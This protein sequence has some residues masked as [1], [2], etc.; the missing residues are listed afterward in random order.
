MKTRTIF[1]F[2]LASAVALV[3]LATPQAGTAQKAQVAA[4]LEPLPEAAWDYAKARHLL[5]RAGFGGSPAEVEKLHA[6]GLRKA[7][8]YLVDYHLIPDVH[9]PLASGLEGLDPPSLVK[10]SPQDKAKLLGDKK[11]KNDVQNMQELRRWWANKMVQ[12]PRPLEEKLVLF[13]H[14]IFATE[15]RTVRNAMSMSLQN[16]LF[17]EH[18]AGNY[19]KLLHAIIYDAA[20]LRYLDNNTNKKGKP[21]EN[22]AREIMEL[23]SMGESQGYTEKDVQQ[24]AR[25]LTG[26]TFD[27]KTLEPKFIAKEHDDGD[28]TIFGKTQ[29]FNGDQFVDLILEQ[30][31][32]S[33][34]IA[35]RLFNYFVYDEPSQELIG[36]LATVLKDGKYEIKPFLR[37]VFLSREFYSPKAMGTHHK[38]PAQLVVGTLRI[39]GIKEVN[40][41]SLVQAM[42][43]MNQDLFDPPNVKGWDGGEAWINSVTL[44]ARN[45]FT[46]NLVSRGLST[47]P[48]KSAEKGEKGDKKGKPV[49]PVL[50]LD[51]VGALKDQKIDT[52][53]AVVDFWVRALLAVPLNEQN[54]ARLVAALGELPPPDQWGQRKDEINRKI[55]NLLIII[56]SL[57]EYQLA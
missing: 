40:G 3:F 20:M 13:W 24:G 36:Q 53:A 5:F 43:N 16:Q 28:I 2:L 55:G 9:V 33:R 48:V 27:G 6:M 17:R 22:L 57:P 54:R 56:M 8:D 47:K 51:F 1:C 29:K 26:Y 35:Y 21:N 25:A 31:A 45:N 15:W 41:E 37:T 46:T 39:L 32:T 52:A 50:K 4:N 10:T 14:G 18:A 49:L 23:F 7:V 38:S 44:F 19:G 34:F 12:S 42:R 30:P 11:R